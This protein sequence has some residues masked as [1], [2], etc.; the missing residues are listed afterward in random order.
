MRAALAH[1]A[2]VQHEDLVGVDDGAQSVRDGDRRPPVHEHRERALDLRL[3]LAVDGA[4]RLV[5]HEQ[6]GSAAMARANESS[7]RSPTLIDAPRSPST[8]A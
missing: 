4:R 6:R 8:W 2:V 5:E 3:D 7:C 1:L